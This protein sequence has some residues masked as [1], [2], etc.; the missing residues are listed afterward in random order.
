MHGKS[1]FVIFWFQGFVVTLISVET[2]PG[3][4]PWVPCLDISNFRIIVGLI[5]LPV[6]PGFALGSRSCYF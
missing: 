5:S 4:V 3:I 1:V 2:S 6:F